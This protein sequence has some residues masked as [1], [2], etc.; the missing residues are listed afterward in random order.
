MILLLLACSDPELPGRLP[1]DAP[2]TGLSA[3]VW[4]QGNRDYLL[5]VQVCHQDNCAETDEDGYAHLFDLPE[6]AISISVDN[7][8]GDD[9][10][11]PLNLRSNYVSR[12]AQRSLSYSVLPSWLGPMEAD[13]GV[14]MVYPGNLEEDTPTLAGVTLTSPGQEIWAVHDFEPAV[15]ENVS[16]TE[17]FF[18]LF[19]LPPGELELTAT[20]PDGA[21]FPKS[22]GWPGSDAD[23]IVVPVEVGRVTSVNIGCVAF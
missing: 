12:W 9:L 19:D 17:S 8:D 11:L 13:T 22:V 20:H 6:G 3:S 4:V 14:V 5:G 2:Q 18:F 7:A 10:L 16:S 1:V 15:L 21:C 23:S